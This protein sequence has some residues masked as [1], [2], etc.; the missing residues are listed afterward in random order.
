MKT[1]LD[2]KALSDLSEADIEEIWQFTS[3]HVTRSRELFD[4]ML[5]TR[6]RVYM[7]R[8]REGR[9]RGFAAERIQRGNIG[10]RPVAV[11]FGSMVTLDEDFRGAALIH[12]AS[13]QAA[14]SERI[15]HPRQSTYG[16]GAISSYRVLASIDRAV[17]EYWPHPRRPMPS[18]VR[19]MMDT[20]IPGLFASVPQRR[21]VPERGVVEVEVTEQ[22]HHKAHR[23]PSR[24]RSALRE[25]Y[26]TMNP[27]ESKGDALFM[28]VP[29]HVPNL[30]WLVGFISRR[31][32]RRLVTVRSSL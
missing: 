5:L 8:D 2:T 9:L 12:L 27:G 7:I 6:D 14:L 13:L 15:R 26:D 3:K 1:R 20:V 18:H 4:A 30:L 10:G 22:W 17:F 24:E 32:A 11:V 16:A 19:E 28:L 21:W 29:L 31:F 23:D 25:W